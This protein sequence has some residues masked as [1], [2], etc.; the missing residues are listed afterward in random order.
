MKKLFKEFAEFINKGNAIAL[1]IGVIIGGAFSQIVSTINTE[2]ISPLVGLVLGGY[3]LSESSALK[4]VLKPEVLDEFGEVIS[5]E[6][7]IYWGSLIQAVI[8]FLLTAVVLFAI[9]KITSKAIEAAKSAERLE[10]RVQEFIAENI[11]GTVET[12]V[13]EP[14]VEEVVVEE[15]PVVEEKPTE[16]VLLL[17][18]I[19]D[20]LKKASEG[21]KE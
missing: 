11:E 7:A 4:T 21:N 3:N 1:A 17:S 5:P 15:A 14:V 12:P 13:E 6:N 8:D 20:L 16:E 19:R 18:E 9:F 2:I 10:E